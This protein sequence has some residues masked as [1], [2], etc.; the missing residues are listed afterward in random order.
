MAAAGMLAL[1]LLPSAAAAGSR[2]ACDVLARAELADLLPQGQELMVS[3]PLEYGGVRAVTCSFGPVLGASVIVSVSEDIG[4]AVPDD[5]AE[6]MAR[7]IELARLMHSEDH[8]IEEVP[9]LGAAALWN[10]EAGW[11]QVWPRDGNLMLV[12]NPSEMGDPRTAAEDVAR[13]LLAVL[14]GDG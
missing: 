9:D 13:R 7:E 5:A 4:G 14:P 12:V 11:L 1:A 3:G 10:G 6:A 8:P 2:E